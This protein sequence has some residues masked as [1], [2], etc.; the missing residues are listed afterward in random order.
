M[1]VNFNMFGNSQ[2][3]NIV[4]LEPQNMMEKM[5]NSIKIIRSQHNL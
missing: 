5:P 3:R 2:G 1:K 4:T